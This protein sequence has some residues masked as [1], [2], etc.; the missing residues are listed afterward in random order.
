MGTKTVLMGLG[1]LAFLVYIV[2]FSGLVLKQEPL[3]ESD[4]RDIIKERYPSSYGDPVFEE[5]CTICDS[6]GCRS[7]G[8][9]CWKINHTEEDSSGSK[10]SVETTIDG[11]TGEE[12]G[13]SVKPCTEWWCD[14]DPCDYQ[15]TEI[16]ENVTHDY[17]NY[18]CGGSSPVCDP[19]FEMCRPCSSN[20]EC[21][22]EETY[23]DNETLIHV[24]TVI[25]TSGYSVINET[26]YICQVFEGE[27]LLL[28]N[29]TTLEECRTISEFYSKCGTMGC[30]F[31]PSFGMIPY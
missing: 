5:E 28:M 3:S 23:Y 11:G 22:M 6:M 17:T 9:P 7:Y 1:L 8:G 20:P 4:V 10:A 12:V 25:G 2:L 13:E 27:D 21:L 15:H 29:V 19:E 14:A 18:G 30:K 16:I 24:F 26:D 31:E